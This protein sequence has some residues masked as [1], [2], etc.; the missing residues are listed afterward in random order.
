MLK[1]VLVNT[2]ESYGG[3]AIAAN[4]LISA[5]KKHEVDAKL[6]VRNKQSDNSDAIPFN[7]SFFSKVLSLLLFIFERFRILMHNKLS[8]NNLFAISIANTGNDI[9]KS[10]IIKEA[11]IIHI[12]WINQ[13]FLSLRD[14]EKLTTLRK[15][16]VWTMHDQWPYTGICHYTGGCSK[17]TDTCSYCPMLENS[18]KADL[19][20]K[21]FEKKKYIYKSNT[22]TLVGCSRWIADEAKKSKLCYNTN[23]FSIPNPIDITR[24]NKRDKIENRKYFN[25]PSDKKLILFGA[26]N[27]TDKRKGFDYM[28]TSCDLLCDQKK[29]SQ[30]DVVIVVFGGKTNEIENLL[31]YNIYDIGY[32]R[33]EQSMI[34]LYNAVD[35]FLIPSLEDNLPNT[36]MEAMSCGTPCVGFN[37][38]GIPEMIDH[39]HNGYIAEY[40]NAEDLAKGICWVL[41]EADYEGISSKAREKAVNNYSEDIIARQYIELYKSVLKNHMQIINY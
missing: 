12:H 36:I 2:F 35:L 41:N 28:K 37:T 13:G 9:S 25:L 11:D 22:I 30:E 38:G 32:I 24:Y 21:T 20:Y 3:A 17:Y 29:L 5:L 23:I 16:I 34:R 8:K 31:P 33:D 4:R 26:C 7:T 10:K 15:P 14:L 39:L 40:K 18:K 27:V 1:V 19:S 6:L